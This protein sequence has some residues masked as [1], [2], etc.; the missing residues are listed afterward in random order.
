[1]A[2]NNAK[3]SIS[4]STV[5]IIILAVVIVLMLIFGTVILIFESNE[6][7]ILINYFFIFISFWTSPKHL[8]LVG[9]GWFCTARES[10]PDYN[11]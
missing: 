9:I 2:E 11:T 7:K 8:T 3:K 1:M 10:E 4:V 6:K 5:V